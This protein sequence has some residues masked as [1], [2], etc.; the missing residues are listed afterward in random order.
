MNERNRE[1]EE[2]GKEEKRKERKD[3]CLMYN[4]KQVYFSYEESMKAFFDSIQISITFSFLKKW[5]V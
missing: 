1:R 5:T 3:S 2:E 4:Y